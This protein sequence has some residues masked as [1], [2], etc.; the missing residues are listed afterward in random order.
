[1][2]SSRTPGSFEPNAW[3]ERRL[4][5]QLDGASP[6][7]DLM[8]TDPIGVGLAPSA[9]A[10]MALALVGPVSY[11]PDPLGL[12]SARAAVA[13]MLEEDGVRALPGWIALTPSTSESYA[14]LFRLFCNPGERV[15]IP[16]PGYPLFEPIARA[17]GVET[18]GYRLLWDGEWHL[19][20]DSCL[21]ALEG[22]RV[23]VTVEPGNP[24]GAVLGPKDRQWLERECARRGVAIV[25]DE[26]FRTPR[27]PGASWLEGR[28]RALTIVLGGM[29]KTCGLPHLKLAWA[30]FAGP[31]DLRG[32]ALVRFEWLEDLF[33]GVATPVQLAL[34]RLLALRGPFR[35]RVAARIAENSERLRAFAA[36]HPE[37]SL[38]EPAAGWMQP[39]R[40]PG[41]RTSEDW[42]MRA[43]EHD[44]AIY[45]GDSFDF[46]TGSYLVASRIVAPD[47]MARGLRGIARALEDQPA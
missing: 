18:L 12:P 43:L 7:Y 23:F 19:D 20:R 3:T 5:L 2:F 37:V 8:Q 47:T 25:A 21:R 35:E 24:T 13:S 40:M 38:V 10:A 17:E 32:E 44:V 29:S 15:A 31:E 28:R 34:P 9:E 22:A 1:M 26:V 42:A 36:A 4:Q 33:L 41:S 46:D 27:T 30:A 6:S 16:R 14:H 39:L 11:A 45:S